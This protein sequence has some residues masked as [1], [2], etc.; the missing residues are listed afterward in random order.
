MIGRIQSRSAFV[1][2]RTEGVHVRSGVLSCTMVLDPSLPGPLVGYAFPR[3]FGN[4][5]R[6]NRLRR[7]LR[8]LVKDHETRMGAGI[9]VFGASPRAA[10]TPF[11]KLAKDL[12]GLLAKVAV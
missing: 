8:V 1:R 5:V 6:R 4:A 7:Q 3:S 12:D 2:V 11:T 10:A 9:Y